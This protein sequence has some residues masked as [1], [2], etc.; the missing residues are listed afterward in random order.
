MSEKAV[1]Q[2]KEKET[3]TLSTEATAPTHRVAAK[4]SISTQSITIT[5]QIQQLL[6]SFPASESQ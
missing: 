5:Y 4:A 1:A 6:S 3:D 2:L